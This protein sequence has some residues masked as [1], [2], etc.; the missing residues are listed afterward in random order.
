MSRRETHRL[1]MR[2][3]GPAGTALSPKRWPRTRAAQHS[4]AL[5]AVLTT[6]KDAYFREPKDRSIP[7]PMLYSSSSPTSS[8]VLF[9]NAKGWSGAR[10]YCG[11]DTGVEG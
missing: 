11:Q 9:A 7:R 5:I 2:P 4:A 1:K 8:S 10:Q 3:K 6:T